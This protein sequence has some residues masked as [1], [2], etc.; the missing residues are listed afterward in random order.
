MWRRSVAEAGHPRDVPEKPTSPAGRGRDAIRGMFDR[1]AAENR[2]ALLP[3]LMAGIPDVE[4]SIELFVTMAEAGAD[5]FEL[6]IPY[7][8]PLMDGPV[9]MAAGETALARGVTVDVALEILRGVVDRTGKPVVVMTYVNPV[10]K[11]GIDSFFS[12]VAM[13]GGSG[14]ILADLP[15]EE[16]GPFAVAADAVGIGLVPFAAPTTGKLRL[17]AVADI[18]PV[19]V[20]GI[21]EIGVTGER[22]RASTRL[23]ALAADVRT[24]MDA[25]LVFGVGISNPEQAA[26]AAQIGDGVIV[27]TAIVRR[28]MEAEDIAGACRV[29]HR[30]VEE[31]A[32]S[33][34]RE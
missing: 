9:I 18:E 20:Y 5:G 24:A 33:M 11:R 32:R 14:V 25:P 19:F 26:S 27:G 7:A 28:V 23:E 34:R 29:V 1:A 3:Y 6:G 2:A 30:F 16:A 8:D 15:I 17:A 22:D 10:L 12:E 31:L 21:A 4:G 13:A